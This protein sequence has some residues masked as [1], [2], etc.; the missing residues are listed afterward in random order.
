M[1]DA[2]ATGD[3]VSLRQYI[4]TILRLTDKALELQAN[5][6]RLELEP[7]KMRLATLEQAS[8][9]QTAQWAIMGAGLGIALGALLAR[10]VR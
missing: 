6:L 7:I 2:A 1:S 8:A 5:A 10:F 4:E 9:R 3:A